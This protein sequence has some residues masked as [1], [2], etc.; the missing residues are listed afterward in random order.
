MPSKGSYLLFFLGTSFVL[1]CAQTFVF[2][3]LRRLLRRDF[4]QKAKIAVPV[5]RWLF[6]LM[7]L[8][9]AFLF[10][11]RDIHADIPLLTNIMLYPFTVWVF[12]ML[13]WAII[14]IPAVIFRTIKNKFRVTSTI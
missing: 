3:Q 8:P 10:F 14:L 5:F 4:P 9:I 6:I 1:V 7:N 11:R 2:F 13:M 12:L